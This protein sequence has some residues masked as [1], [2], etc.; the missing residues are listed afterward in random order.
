V[1]LS[2]PHD[3]DGQT[4]ALAALTVWQVLRGLATRENDG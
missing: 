2:P 1:E 4:A 3:R